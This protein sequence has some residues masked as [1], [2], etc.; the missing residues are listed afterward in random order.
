[1]RAE[2]DA[3]NAALAEAVGLRSRLEAAF[4]RLAALEA[5]RAAAGRR[6]RD[7][8]VRVE[9]GQATTADLAAAQQ[10]AEKAATAVARQSDLVEGLRV[11]LARKVNALEPLT[12]AARLA[13]EQAAEDRLAA[14]DRAFAKA[15]HQAIRYAAEAVAVADAAGLGHRVGPLLRLRVP[16]SMLRTDAAPLRVGMDGED[17]TPPTPTDETRRLAAAAAAIAEASRLLEALP[18]EARQE[19]A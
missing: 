7:V 8:V 18:I 10:A 15:A 4:D 2:L 9:L 3:L 6:A 12:G 5:E 17:A 16:R 11:A 19:A 14:L 1:M 13:V